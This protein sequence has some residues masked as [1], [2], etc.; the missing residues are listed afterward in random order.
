[1]S[2]FRFLAPIL[3]LLLLSAPSLAADWLTMDVPARAGV[4][5]PFAVRLV[6]R[7]PADDLAVEWN[8]RTLHVPF[9]RKGDA[10]VAEFLLGT[11]LKRK[12]GTYPLGLNV[13]LW[14]CAFPFSRTV[15]VVESEW[16]HETLTVPPRMVR[17]PKSA[18][19]R[20][21]KERELV[22]AALATATP[23]R[24]WTVP[25]TRP[26]R[27]RM[28]SRF[29]LY[30][31]FN[32]DVKG[33]HTGLDFRAYAGTPIHAMA[34]GTVVLTGSFYYAGNVVFIDHGLGLISMSCHLSKRLVKVGDRVE[35]GQ[36]IG[37]SGATGRVTGAHLHLGVFL[38]GETVDPE[39]FFDGILDNEFNQNSVISIDKEV[40]E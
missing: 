29:G 38:L 40:G 5:K 34:A 30:R 12:L 33:R 31:V 21:R 24:F 25:F 17:P 9:V 3:L 15:E 37:L 4:G 10:F 26:V 27:G 22:R 28:L 2:L 23:E 8:G 14:A 6:S 1:M 36:K 19:E 39:P 32:G 18:L 20:I 35:A 16:D 11:G 13:H 7:Y